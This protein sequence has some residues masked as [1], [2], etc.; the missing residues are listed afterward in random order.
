MNQ[1]RSESQPARRRLVIAT[2]NAHKIAEIRA[3]LGDLP[4]DVMTPA[5]FDDFPD[6]EETGQT[7]EANARIKAEAAH[8]ATGLWA[9]ADDSGIEIDALDG[10]PGVVSA[11]YAGPGCTY[12]DNNEKVLRLMADVPDDKRGARFQCVAALVCGPGVVEFFEGTVE[13]QITR[14]VRGEH[15]FGYDPIFWVPEL[16]HTFAEAT[17]EEK[18]RLSHRGRA[19][20]RAAGRLR[21]LVA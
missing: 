9:L 21:E 16:G 20:R 6:P 17:A 2:N 10:A 15:G 3:I 18:N 7:F 12:A 19:F 4:L 11:R 1:P 5:D 13:G 8:A 14:E